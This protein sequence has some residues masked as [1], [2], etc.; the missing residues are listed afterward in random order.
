MS[1]VKLKVGRTWWQGYQS[2]VGTDTMGDRGLPLP[3]GTWQT[4]KEL[5]QWIRVS[6]EKVRSTRQEPETRVRGRVE[7]SK[8]DERGEKR[9]GAREKKASLFVQRGW[10]GRRGG[11]KAERSGRKKQVSRKERRSEGAQEKQENSTINSTARAQIDA[12]L[13][14]QRRWRWKRWKQRLKLVHALLR[15]KRECVSGCEVGVRNASEDLRIAVCRRSCCGG[16]RERE[17]MERETQTETEA[18]EL[19]QLGPPAALYNLT[20]PPAASAQAPAL[21]S[22]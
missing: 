6:K 5:K 9:R 8:S 1:L 4:L 3:G 16:G 14:K 11:K 18:I 19:A 15:A 22:C 7:V 21:A 13:Q 2:R 10:G 17:R 12:A 20:R